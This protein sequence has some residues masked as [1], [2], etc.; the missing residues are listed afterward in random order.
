[1]RPSFVQIEEQAETRALLRRRA[2]PDCDNL[3]WLYMGRM[4]GCSP[5][6]FLVNELSS[7]VI[8][9]GPWRTCGLSGQPMVTLSLQA[10]GSPRDEA[11]QLIGNDRS[12]LALNAVR[13]LLNQ[14]SLADLK[15]IRFGLVSFGL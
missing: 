5:I 11:N 4:L 13:D 14:F 6:L 2:I 7:C 1:M 8:P 10:T 15:R 9:V 12:H 3:A